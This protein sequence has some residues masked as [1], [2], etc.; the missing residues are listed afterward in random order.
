[1][2]FWTSSAFLDVERLPAWSNN[3]E[4][5]YGRFKLLGF[6]SPSTINLGKAWRAAQPDKL[7]FIVV[8]AL[9]LKYQPI[10]HLLLIETVGQI[11]YRVEVTRTKV[12]E[13]QWMQQNPQRK[14]VFLN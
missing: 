13:E 4:R 11:S 14:L 7:E 9:N 1:L 6:P 3:P 10:L 5:V 8:G 12:T 2:I